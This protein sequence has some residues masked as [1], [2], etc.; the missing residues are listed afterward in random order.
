VA[1]TTAAV[2]EVVGAVHEA[3]EEISASAGRRPHKAH[4]DGRSAR[5]AE[6]RATRRA[7]LIEAAMA[8]IREHGPGVGMDQIARAAGTSKPVI[9]RYF[10]DKADLYRAIVAQ[11]AGTLLQRIVA[12]LEGVTEP[13]EEI[14]AGVHAFLS[15][16]DEDPDLYRFAVGHPVKDS[17]D[18]VRDYQ[19]TIAEIITQRLRGHLVAHGRDPAAARPWGIATVGFL[20]AA[21]DWWIDHREDMSREQLGDYL[22]AL[23]WGGAAGVYAMGGIE[24]DNRPPEY[25][26]PK[27]DD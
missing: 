21:G 27:L 4:K 16:L 20:R 17:D 25:L 26:F 15:M 19:S 23:L 14:A 9:Y 1:R 2:T 6:H 5:W 13:R 24:L 18:V 11:T 12:A 7:E 10:T 8:A 3:I 22:T